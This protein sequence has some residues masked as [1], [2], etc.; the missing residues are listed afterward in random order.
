MSNRSLELLPIV[1]ESIPVYGWAWEREAVDDFIW[2][3][4]PE[5]RHQLGWKGSSSWIVWSWDVNSSLYVMF[6]PSWLLLAMW[7]CFLQIW[8]A[9]EVFMADQTTRG[10]RRI[11]RSRENGRSTIHWCPPVWIWGPWP[12]TLFLM[13]SFVMTSV[14]EVG[15]FPWGII[16]GVGNMASPEYK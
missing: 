16:G 4:A 10:G 15:V 1:M 13:P 3:V 5:S 8:H 2:C 11:I 6:Y 14:I 9:I 7:Q 12:T